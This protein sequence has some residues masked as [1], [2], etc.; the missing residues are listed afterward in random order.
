MA[1]G[2]GLKPATPMT[3]RLLVGKAVPA[4]QA[5][6]SVTSGSNSLNRTLY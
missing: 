4:S 2:C 3:P 1:K 5:V 6:A